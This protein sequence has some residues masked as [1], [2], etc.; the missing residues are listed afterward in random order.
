V[1]EPGHVTSEDREVSRP[2]FISYATADRKEALTLCKAIERRG[3]KCWISTRDVAPGE[4]YQEAIVRSLRGSRAMV[5][6]FS[7]AANNSDEIKKELSL[8]SRYHVPVMALRIEDV[9]PS[10]AFAYELSTRQWIDAF[11]S[12]DKSIDALTQRIG[13]VSVSTSA[14]VPSGQPATRRARVTA[15][16]A[17]TLIIATAVFLIAL[18][19]VG[20]WVLMRPNRGAAHTMQV[21]LAGFQLLSPDLPTGMPQALSDEMNAAFNNDGQVSVSTASAPP[22]GSSPAYAMSGTIR[23]EGGK[24]KVIVRLTNER[25]G[26][27]LWTNDYSYDSAVQARVPHLAAVESSMVVRCG[28]FGAS[29]Y[30]KPLPDNALIPYLGFCQGTDGPDAEKALNFARKT[31]E[32][33]PDFSSGWS[34]VAVAASGKWFLTNGTDEALR[35]EGLE[36]ADRAIALDPSNS[37]AYAYKAALTDEFD[38]ATQEALLKKALAARPLPC[39]CEHHLYGSFLMETGRVKDAIEQFRAGI[40]VLPLNGDTQFS[41]ADALLNDGSLDEAKKAFDASADLDSDPTA[42]QQMTV[43]AAPYTKDYAGAAKIVFDPKVPA[44]QKFRGVIGGAFQA[45]ASGSADAK[46]KASQTLGAAPLMNARLQVN[47]LALL[48]APDV[49]L[50]K[51]DESLKN[52][53]GLARSALWL[54]SMDA[55]RR[56]PSFPAL[57]ER[58]GLMRYWKSSHTRPDVCS[59]KNPPPFCSM[60]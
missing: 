55:A 8:A 54:P 39:G 5:L 12:W 37:E 58:A 57:L 56:A 45:L 20:G 38:L 18:V 1:N 9:E 30:P 21:R 4:N 36:A 46:T 48:G 41:L 40:A 53:G 44:P 24:I 22:P 23:R 49:A 14:A 52:N 16:P 35:K 43:Y 13:E 2:V 17:R 50:S 32:I 33:A 59:D 10:D 34:G 25:T 31:V 15:F 51:I 19:G 60:I 11:E 7:E 27:T 26:T 3:T 42:R 6:V 28:L 47:L 29:T